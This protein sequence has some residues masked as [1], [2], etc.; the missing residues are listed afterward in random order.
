MA[1]SALTFHWA[2]CG[3]AAAAARFV[4]VPLLDDVI[5]QRAMQQAVTR[6]V[7]AHGR[8]LPAASLSPLWDEQ[9]KGRSRLRRR[10]RAV[11][12][13]LLLFPVRKY[14]ALFGAERGV[15][16]DVMRVVLVARTVDRL[17]GRDPAALTRGP[18]EAE[19]LRAAVDGAMR[20]MDLDLLTAA[21]GEGLSRTRGL[22]AAA[23]GLARRRST[24]ADGDAEPQPERPVVEGATTVN[25]VLQRP[26]VQ[27]LLE[28][29][30]VEVDARLA[31]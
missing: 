26:D 25:E 7:R 16:T 20:G 17:L 22:T 10:L 13:R 21:L 23:V 27:G 29:F 11:G 6:T 5:R 19:A 12:S 4:P 30:D 8:D 28:R 18:G 15:P 31:A 3:I 24:G 14:T 9:H 1:D 2:V